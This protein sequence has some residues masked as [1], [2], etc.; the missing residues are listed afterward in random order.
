MFIVECDAGRFHFP[1]V[2]NPPA[3]IFYMA[4]YASRVKEITVWHLILLGENNDDILTDGML[5]N[6]SG[7]ARTRIRSSDADHSAKNKSTKPSVAQDTVARV[8]MGF[9]DIPTHIK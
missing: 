7:H 1:V 6:D 5:N 2:F 8:D 3:G 9:A 4:V